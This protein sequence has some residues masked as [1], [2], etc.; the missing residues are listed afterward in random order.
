[1]R[2]CLR[3][4][5]LSML[6]TPGFSSPALTAGLPLVSGSYE[7]VL[8]MDR[9]GRRDRAV[10]TVAEGSRSV[11]LYIYL[12][13]VQADPSHRP[14]LLKSGLTTD[15][16]LQL[17]GRDDGTL[18]VGYGCGGCSNDHATALVVAYRNG[19][20]LVTGASYSWDTREGAGYCEIDLQA[21]KGFTSEGPEGEQEHLPLEGMFA[22][23]KFVDWSD[24]LRPDDCGG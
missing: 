10:A 5:L 22:P 8:D 2:S 13:P 20:F 11:D 23:V 16:L 12:A 7:T 9:D 6:S 18:I 21:G 15:L 1:M 14:S 3:H 4:S 19:E 17:E 24:E